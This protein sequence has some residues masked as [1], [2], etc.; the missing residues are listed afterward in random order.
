MGNVSSTLKVRLGSGQ[1]GDRNVEDLSGLNG[2]PDMGT[3]VVS[4][5]EQG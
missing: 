5:E 2:V 1:P 4:S 3:I